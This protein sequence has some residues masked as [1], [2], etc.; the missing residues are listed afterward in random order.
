MRRYLLIAAVV[1]LLLGVGVIIYFLFLAKKP[2]VTTSPG[3]GLPIAGQGTSQTGIPRVVVPS[4][5]L[6]PRLLSHHD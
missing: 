5:L 1:I 4:S 2:V 6:T 3:V